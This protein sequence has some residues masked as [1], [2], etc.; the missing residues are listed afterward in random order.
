MKPAHIWSAVL[1]IAV[2]AGACVLVVRFAPIGD[3][4]RPGGAEPSTVSAPEPRTSRERP[5]EREV[6]VE[7]PADEQPTAQDTMTG[8]PELVDIDLDGDCRI[9]GRVLAPDGTPLPGAEVSWSYRKTTTNR[10]GRFEFRAPWAG[11]YEVRAEH[12]SYVEARYGPVEL[13]RNQALRGL[14]LRLAGG[15]FVEGVVAD[16]AQ[17]PIAGATVYFHTEH[18]P[19]GDQD[20]RQRSAGGYVWTHRDGRYRSTAVPAG[21]YVVSA[22]DD[23]HLISPEQV[24][25]VAVGQTTNADIAL[26]AGWTISGYVYGVDGKPV[27]DVTLSTAVRE[28]NGW[29]AR[30]ATSRE[31]GGFVLRGLYQEQYTISARCGEYY[32]AE[33]TVLAPA[34]GAEIQLRPYPRFTGRVIDKATRQPVEEFAVNLLGQLISDEGLLEDYV[35]PTDKELGVSHYP[36]GW[37]DMPCGTGEHRVVV[38]APGYARA[39]VEAVRI[40]DDGE[41]DGLLVELDRGTT[42]TFHVT[43]AAGGVPIKNATVCKVNVTPYNP[44]RSIGRQAKTLTWETD[45]N[46]RCS[47]EHFRSVQGEFAVSHPDFAAMR[48]TVDV[49]IG[50]KDMVVDVALDRGLTLRGRVVSEADGGPIAEAKVSYVVPGSDRWRTYG[51]GAGREAVTGQDGLFA[52][53]HVPVGECTISVVHPE[54]PL[55]EIGIELTE[56]SNE[57]LLFELGGLGGV[58][59]T[60]RSEDG[61]PMPG[62]HVSMSGILQ[63]VGGLHLRSALGGGCSTLTDE[64]GCYAFADIEP[65]KYTLTFCPGG[66]KN[67]EGPRHEEPVVVEAWTDTRADFVLG[68]VTLSGYITFAGE[69]APGVTVACGLRRRVSERTNSFY[70]TCRADEQGRYQLDGIPAG[71]YRLAVSRVHKERWNTDTEL[72]DEREVSIGDTRLDVDIDLGPQSRSIRGVVLLADG[73]PAARAQVRLVSVRPADNRITEV[74]QAYE[75]GWPSWPSTESDGTFVLER[76]RPGAY[77]LVVYEPGY[78]VAVPEIRVPDDADLTGLRIELARESTV[79]VSVHVEQGEIPS[80]VRFACFD[81]K[82]CLVLNSSSRVSTPGGTARIHELGSGR[83]RLLA[84]AEGYAMCRQDVV[85]VSRQETHV[86]VHFRSGRALAV[87]VIDLD[88]EPVYAADVLVDWREDAVLAHAHVL[89]AEPMAIEGNNDGPCTF[90]RLADGDYTVRVRCDGYEDAAV[91]VTVAGIDQTLEVTL[92]PA[93]KE[94]P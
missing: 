83:Y 82:G 13:K 3:K 32:S 79:S 68:G 20:E 52:F 11:T 77:C 27:P 71:T 88:G 6:A 48:V 87:R 22:R 2:V 57:E 19:L 44:F 51:R 40:V 60:V 75:K 69:P 61:S 16:T 12:P 90:N 47:A 41:P 33:T 26:D 65:G 15:G 54:Y 30:R 14:V 64:E 63:L 59:G 18:D 7:Q 56:A 36:D 53:E 1:A 35:D 73:R 94:R 8:A 21:R 5:A 31:D 42:L 72:L 43:D 80:S 76:V 84:H 46:G 29:M 89:P 78:A 66:E 81:E 92:K 25:E 9:T 93:R 70:A 37:F 91:P 55:T 50:E 10:T 28:G 45:A 58:A 85:V 49:G 24:V 74:I 34:D 39:V 86:D 62:V 23:E 67:D 38:D 4:A 17:N